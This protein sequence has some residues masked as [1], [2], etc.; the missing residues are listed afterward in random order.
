M[1]AKETWELLARRYADKPDDFYLSVGHFG[2]PNPAEAISISNLPAFHAFIKIP[3]KS[4]REWA[5]FES[6]AKT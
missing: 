5:E 6:E 1:T 2:L 3:M 4:V